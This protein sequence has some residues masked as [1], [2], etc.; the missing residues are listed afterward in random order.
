MISEFNIIVN[1]MIQR[2]LGV[3]GV[4][5]VNYSSIIGNGIFNVRIVVENED[6]VFIMGFVMFSEGQKYVN[7]SLM[8]LDDN[9]FE[10]VEIVMVNLIEVQLVGGYLVFFGKFLFYLVCIL[11]FLIL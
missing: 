5:R 11:F 2:L 10:D 6:Y 8:V 1:L 7:V 3:Q 4:V 9:V